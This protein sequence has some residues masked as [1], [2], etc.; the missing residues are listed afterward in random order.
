MLLIDL[1]VEPPIEASGRRHAAFDRRRVSLRW[2]FGTILTGLVGGGLIGLAIYASLEQNAIAPRQPDFVASVPVEPA[3]GPD[4]GPRRAD[5]L[6]KNADIVADKQTFSAPV[7]VA[8]GDKQVMRTQSFTRVSTTLALAPTGFADQVPDFNPMKLLAGNDQS[9]AEGPIDPGP[10]LDDSDMSFTV[11]DLST[12]DPSHFSGGLGK[13]E[14]QAQV[15][16][17]LRGAESP[18]DKLT[19]LPA[20]MLLMRT[21]RASLNFAGTLGFAAPENPLANPFSSIEVKM[22][23]ENVTVV[24]QSMRGHEGADTAERLVV[25]RHGETLEGVLQANGADAAAVRGIVTAFGARR[26]EAPVAE[27]RRLRLLI[28]GRSG[29]S[30]GQ[31]ARVAVYADETLETTVAL[32]DSG[33][34][35]QVSRLE[36]KPVVAAKPKDDDDEDDDAGGMRLYQSLYETALKQG[37]P[38]PIIDDLVRIFGNDVDFQRSVSAG[39][40]LDCFYADADQDSHDELLFA[41]VTVHN[42]SYRYYRFQDPEG[43]VDYFDENGRATQKFLIRKPV[44]VGEVT[45]G[46]GMRFHPVLGYSRPHTGVDW[47]AP[48]GTPILAAGSGVLLTV[49]RSSS[50]GNHIE[51]QHPN[52]YV[53]TYSHM[54]GFARGMADGT[55]VRQ[56]QVIGYLGQ[57]GLATG[58]H[59]HYEVI[60]NGHFVDPMRVKLARTREMDGKMM[61]SFKKEHDRI[62]ALMASAPNAMPDLGTHAAAN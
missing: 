29:K 37:I 55:H 28:V 11:K 49:E 50:Y 42:E 10:A 27:G 30:A 52:G 38:K 47:G 41:S 1:G 33:D 21:S 58:P 18:S 2:M 12:A 3:S 13:E 54:S 34:Y 22:V 45:S 15:S 25:L 23:P 20:Q 51:I 14:V 62:N 35:V 56:G 5:R 44:P 53:T 9:P 16:E 48:I 4:D 32:E 31:I 19:M 60:V 57:T 39:D 40:T 61:T 43:S 36:A 26:G 6:I 46:F 7:T 24:Q 17:F 59:L 8:V